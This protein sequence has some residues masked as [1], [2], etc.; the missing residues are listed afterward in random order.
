MNLQQLNQSGQ[1]V[2]SFVTTALVALLFTAVFW[3][4]LELY[5]IVADYKR[6]KED[7]YTRSDDYKPKR[8]IVVQVAVFLRLINGGLWDR[9]Q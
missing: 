4:A 7:Y 5:N 9:V 3:F 6:K 8:S 2:R 1:S